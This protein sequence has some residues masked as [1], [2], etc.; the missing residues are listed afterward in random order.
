MSKRTWIINSGAEGA[1]YYG[2]EARAG[3][4]VC[5]WM[6]LLEDLEVLLGLAGLPVSPAQRVA[7][8]LP[9]LTATNRFWSDSFALDPVGV[10]EDLIEFRDRLMMA[11]WNGQGN[12]ERLQ[13]LSNLFPEGNGGIPDRLK[14]V[15]G[16]ATPAL[17]STLRLIIL[18]EV[19]DVQG[20][21]L[22]LIQA[23]QQ[24]GAEV[25][26]RATGESKPKVSLFTPPDSVRSGRASRGLA[27]RHQKR[28]PTGS[29]YWSR[30]RA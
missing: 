27:G 28:K 9:R 8:L 1:C 20:L 10:A 23:L 11:G 25:E 18:C 4:R 17:A 14:I 6:G 16:S 29:H 22:E 12:S 3:E 2:K 13:K 24:A 5:G 7:N 26:F 19:Q 21:H 15:I 30:Y